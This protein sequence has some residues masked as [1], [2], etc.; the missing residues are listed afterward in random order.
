ME[1]LDVSG[2]GNLSQLGNAQYCSGGETFLDSEWLLGE[3][4]VDEY[5]D[6]SQPTRMCNSHYTS[7]I[8]NINFS[9]SIEFLVSGFWWIIRSTKD[10]VISQHI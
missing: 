7:K 4:R 6:T 2:E 5:D 10:K 9:M 8:N 1:T 3:N